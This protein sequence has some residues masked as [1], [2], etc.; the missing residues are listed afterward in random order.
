MPKGAVYKG[1]L[2]NLEDR[3]GAAIHVWSLFALAL[4]KISLDSI[5]A[6]IREIVLLL[7]LVLAATSWSV[8]ML[9][10]A[11]EEPK[12]SR[13]QAL[14]RRGGVR[15]SIVMVIGVFIA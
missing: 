12:G 4:F 7:F 14:A 8:Q 5:D 15:I 2:L 10:L 11:N 1:V 9:R 13:Q 6:T 3:R